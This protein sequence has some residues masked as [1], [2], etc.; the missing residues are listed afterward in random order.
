MTA[1]TSP[2]QPRL[3]SWKEIAAY[4]KR[5][6]R[7]VRRWE[8]DRGLP[9]R[10]LPGTR[11]GVY[12]LVNEVD[13]WIQS[14][15]S[16][17]ADIETAIQSP[18]ALPIAN[19]SWF[20]RFAAGSVLAIAVLLLIAVAV[21]PVAPR[22]KGRAE[23]THSGWIKRALIRRGAALYYQSREHGMR[24]SIRR[25]DE[26]GD[27]QFLAELPPGP[28]VSLLD[29]SADGSRILFRQRICAGC[30]SNIW[31]MTPA[32][33]HPVQVGGDHAMAGAWSADGKKLAYADGSSLF[34]A[35]P[36]GT[37]PKRLLAL[38][39]E[40]VTDLRWSP[41]GRQVRFVLADRL[42]EH[43]RLWEFRFDR[44]SAAPLL[45]GWS[46]RDTDEERG[47]QWTS[48]GRYFV[49][50]AIHNG[51][52]GI[53]ALR[54][55]SSLFGRWFAR[56]IFLSSL[57]GVTDS[58]VTGPHDNQIFAIVR[59]SK[60]GELLRLDA[61]TQQFALVPRWGWLS[62][63]D[64]AFSPDG[65]RVAY[66]SYPEGRLWSAD[67]DGRNPHLLTPGTQRG[68][69]AQWAPDGRRIAFMAW[70][71][72]TNG[73]TWI[74]IVS[75]DGRGSMDPVPLSF[76]QGAPNWTSNDELVFGENGAVF[77]IA[78]T[79]SLHVFDLR[80]GKLAD[81]PGT[82]GLW[83]A[84]PRPTGRYIA[85]QT[86]D[87]RRLL[88]YDRQTAG[89]T[90]LFRS[91]EGMLG[92]NPTWSRDGAYIYM[93][94]PW[95]HDP[96]IYRIRVADQKVERIAGLAGIQ[97]VEAGGLWMGFA[98]DDSLMILRQVEG[99]EIDSWDWVAR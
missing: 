84:R 32:H 18:A 79:C 48:D 89:L 49:F 58:V 47:G 95:A 6:V 1:E 65:L 19:R 9:I 80:T 44:G 37:A 62:G 22:I 78:S 64:L 87:K 88:L 10:R 77:P 94:A 40:E 13:D 68:A 25:I 11:P 63:E 31:Y 92:D 4:L 85:A 91:P 56:P 90:D 5:D 83:T 20:G 33:T 28:S 2:K 36:D 75:P 21:A 73:P 97:R 55:D 76:W 59:P 26:S 29:V 30:P 8:K 14:A 42:Y 61:K 43:Q 67:L 98:P 52:I 69:L 66:L 51:T 16:S 99:S 57:E 38:P 23:I 35:N 74:R 82:T 7:T 24:D 96:A 41:D 72:G 39:S 50:I 12:A 81:L 86:N 45:P 93:D 60:R 70:K 71:D 27:D 54:C 46:R 53:W 3:E 34:L 15:V 17:P